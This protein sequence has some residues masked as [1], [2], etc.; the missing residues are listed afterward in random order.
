[1]QESERVRKIAA[2]GGKGFRQRLSSALNGRQSP[3]RSLAT[4]TGHANVLRASH[5]RNGNLVRTSAEGQPQ[6]LPP[7]C[8]SRQ[9][10]S[11]GG[12]RSS[13]AVAVCRLLVHVQSDVVHVVSEEPPRLFSE[14]ACPLRSA[15]CNTSCSSSTSHSNNAPG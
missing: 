14:S 3:S 4:V 1:M 11:A 9:D 10:E 13:V 2:S 8:A 7:R 12:W 5:R 6:I 15:F